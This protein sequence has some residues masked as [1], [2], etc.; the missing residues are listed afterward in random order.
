M[1]AAT[2]VQA[3]PRRALIVEPHDGT[4]NLY[5]AYLQLSRW[6]VEEAEDGRVALAVAL[7]APPD[8]IVSEVRLPGFSGLDLCRQLRAD[9][10]T[11][12]VPFV[13]ILSDSQPSIRD[14]A[15]RS[16]ADRVLVKPCLPE[17]L[18]GE[19]QRLVARTPVSPTRLFTRATPHRELP[20]PEGARRRQTLVRAYQRQVTTMP[21]VP[22]P[23]LVC[24]ACDARLSYLQSHVGGVSALHQE[25][26]DYFRCASGCGDFQYRHRTRRLRRL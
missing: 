4:R 13:F 11:S 15:L 25:Q 7:T 20:S 8:V 2:H 12:Q 26:W 21:P 17:A 9:P 22:P 3:R 16:G 24:P 5:R 1:P 10:A 14:L 18:E 19:L 6:R 23:A